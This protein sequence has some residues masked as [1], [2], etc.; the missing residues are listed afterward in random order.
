MLQN[1]LQRCSRNKER[2][3]RKPA[4]WNER[5]RYFE[6]RRFIPEEL[7]SIIGKNEFRENVGANKRE[8]ER[9]AIAL[10][11]RWEAELD[12]A[13]DQ[14]Q[15]SKPT[16]TM[17]VKA[18]YRAELEADDRERQHDER[19]VID[20]RQ[21][22]Q[23]RR[24][25]ILRLIASG[26]IVGD[27]AE[28]LIGY[29]ADRLQ[30]KSH[31]EEPATSG[32]FPRGSLHSL[33]RARESSDGSTCAKFCTRCCRLPRSAHPPHPIPAYSSATADDFPARMFA[34]VA[35]F[36]GPPKGQATVMASRTVAI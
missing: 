24:A 36:P 27:E 5:R 14:L 30:A 3:V 8:A 23:S 11:N 17:A 34:S 28:A 1:P 22:T 12:E 33:A 15:A 4:L 29:A 25:S 32:I 16:L 6:A 10:Q 19:T 2:Q 35:N 9:R 13:R 31:G 18:H 20:L 21:R 7:R 26:Q